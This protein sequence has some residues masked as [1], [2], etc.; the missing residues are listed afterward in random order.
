MFVYLIQ[1]HFNYKTGI[2]C[3]V[4]YDGCVD[5]PCAVGECVDVPAASYDPINGTTYYCDIAECPDGYERKDING[6]I[7][8]DC[9]GTVVL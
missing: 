7:E 2:A 5:K 1:Y 3:N 8:P 6:V 9:T 4:D